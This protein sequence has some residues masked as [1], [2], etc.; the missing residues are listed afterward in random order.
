[1]HLNQF[2][3][4]KSQVKCVD[5]MVR[6]EMESVNEL[7]Q[8]AKKLHSQGITLSSEQF[9][10]SGSARGEKNDQLDSLFCRK[11]TFYSAGAHI[12]HTKASMAQFGNEKWKMDSKKSW[13]CSQLQLQLQL[14]RLV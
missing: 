13:K 6:G 10:F 14:L 5:I 2:G 4:T 9:K 8:V 11:I 7:L 3:A 12:S 1:M